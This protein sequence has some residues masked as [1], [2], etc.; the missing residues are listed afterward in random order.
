MHAHPT[1]RQ[2]IAGVLRSLHRAC[3][4]VAERHGRRAAG[5]ITAVA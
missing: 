4:G 1:R 3:D 2:A 5:A